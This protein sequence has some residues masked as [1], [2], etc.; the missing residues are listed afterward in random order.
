[1]TEQLASAAT[2]PVPKQLTPFKPGQS[3][4]PRG[5]ASMRVRAAELYAELKP[6]FPDLTA[7]DRVLLQQATLLLAR[8]EHVASIKHAD[9]A[10]RSAGEGRRMLLALRRRNVRRDSELTETF[11]DIATRAQSEAEHKRAA[12]L[13]ADDEVAADGDKLTS[14]DAMAAAPP[15]KAKPQMALD[16]APAKTD[17]ELPDLAE[18]IRRVCRGDVI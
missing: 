9:V 10:L 11:T 6:D 15:S 8:A 18:D 3:G 5:R 14:G 13:A 1:M 16:A 7:T 2:R 17:V 4:N 12:E